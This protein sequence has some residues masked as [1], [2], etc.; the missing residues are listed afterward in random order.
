MNDIERRQIER[1]A[2]EGLG[3]CDHEMS[4]LWAEFTGQMS[5]QCGFLL[6]KSDTAIYKSR[7]ASLMGDCNEQT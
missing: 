5:C 6:S 1:E 3:Y 7:M 4:D 2:L